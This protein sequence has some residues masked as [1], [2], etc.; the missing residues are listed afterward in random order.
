MAIAVRINPIKTFCRFGQFCGFCGSFSSSHE[1]GF[2]W[3]SVSRRSGSL[4]PF[5]MINSWVVRTVADDRCQR[6]RRRRRW[7]IMRGSPIPGIAGLRELKPSR[8][9]SSPSL[10][11]TRG[12]SMTRYVFITLISTLASL[13]CGTILQPLPKHFKGNAVFVKDRLNNL[14]KGFH[15]TGDGIRLLFTAD[16]TN[17]S[18]M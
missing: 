3:E 16:E 18:L 15:H 6:A 7:G 10:E 12:I 5:D 13:V 9:L 4:S 17:H 2:N 14:P 11:M 1:I 8:I